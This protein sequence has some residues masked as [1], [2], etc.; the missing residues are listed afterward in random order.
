[1]VITPMGK[2]DHSL[3][4]SFTSDIKTEPSEGFIDGDLIECF[5]DLS[6]RDMV[7]VVAGL[8]CPV[9]ISKLGGRDSTFFTREMN[10][11]TPK[12][13]INVDTVIKIVEELTRLH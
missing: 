5:L 10:E 4:R 3:W 1:M 6:R 9:S 12:Q 7:D 11:E 8:Q 13:E 2:I